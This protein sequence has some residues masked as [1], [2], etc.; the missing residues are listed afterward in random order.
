ML[1]PLQ[2]LNMMYVFPGLSKSSRIPS[3]LNLE[4]SQQKLGNG[5]TDALLPTLKWIICDWQRDFD[6]AA[7]QT[8]KSC[9][10]S[11]ILVELID[12]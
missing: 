6:H 7:T 5:S 3:F 10:S 9:L 12:N 1:F 8:F 4:E 2:I 11:V